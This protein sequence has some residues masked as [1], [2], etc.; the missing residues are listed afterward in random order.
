MKRNALGLAGVC[1]AGLAS[2]LGCSTGDMR[3][4]EVHYF[5]VGSGEHANF[6]RTTVDAD[7]TLGIAEYRS[8]WFPA[9]SVD[10]LFGDV[11]SDGG[12]NALRFRND[13]EGLIETNVLK[14]TRVYLEEASKPDADPNELRRRA[15]ARRRVLAYPRS[16]GLKPGDYAEIDYDPARGVVTRHGDEK[17]VFIVSS[18]PD[19]VVGKIASF[20]ESSASAL[21]IQNLSRVVQTQVGNDLLAKEGAATALAKLDALLVN[22]L[23]NTV[24]SITN[25]NVTKE[26]GMQ[27]IDLILDLINSL[28]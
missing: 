28:P 18:N 12:V 4:H 24:N 7:S 20:S 26:V 23:T 19:E 11:S 13:L 10:S 15:E 22:Q 17:L 21:T 14:T 6:Y 8:G 1:V 2:L 9:R 27:K 25:Y 3:V 5:K 16:S